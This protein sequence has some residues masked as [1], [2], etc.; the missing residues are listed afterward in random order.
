MPPA[1]LQ[2]RCLVHLFWSN[3]DLNLQR[4]TRSSKLSST[5]VKRTNRHF[6]AKVKATK[7]ASASTGQ[8]CRLRACMHDVHR[9]GLYASD[10][11][12]NHA[13]VVSQQF[14][15]GTMETMRGFVF[16][17]A[18]GG[19]GG[20]G[21]LGLVFAYIL[22]HILRM[23]KSESGDRTCGLASLTAQVLVAQTTRPVQKNWLRA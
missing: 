9:G 15:T 20:R 16:A 18:G 2:R 22:C 10:N 14:F 8:V 11:A 7:F 6:A 1:S 3:H 21:A 5:K 23:R 12:I 13:S 17:G 19:G 4:I